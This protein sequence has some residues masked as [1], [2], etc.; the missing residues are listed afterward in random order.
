MISKRSLSFGLAV[1]FSVLTLGGASARG[2]DSDE[3]K[4]LKARNAELEAKIKK[5]EADKAELQ[6]QLDQLKK[7][8]DEPDGAKKTLSDRL[9]VGQVLAGE[10]RIND[11]TVHTLSVKVTERS[12][13]KVKAT[14]S[15]TNRD[16]KVVEI[17]LE[18]EVNGVRLS[19]KSVGMVTH[20]SL[21]VNLKGEV[22][23]GTS[24]NQEAANQLPVTFRF[25]K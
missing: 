21:S 4:R 11:G 12:G 5:L 3:L 25:R 2:Q 23:E 20:R 7:A 8:G 16:K 17:P 22:L 19:L 6:K 13:K 15:F 24:Y 9:P 10:I 14:L 18:G 1:L